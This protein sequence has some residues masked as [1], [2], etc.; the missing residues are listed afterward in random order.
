[1]SFLASGLDVA[2]INAESHANPDVWNRYATRRGSYGPHAKLSDIWVRYNDIRNLS[3]SRETFNEEHESV[4]YPEARV[5]PSVKDMAFRVMA[6]VG[7]ERLGG[8]L[9]TKIPPHTNCDPHVDRGWHATYYEKFAVQLQSDPLQAFHFEGE[10]FSAK[11]GDLYTFDNSFTHWV[12]NDSEVDRVTLIICIR[13]E[14]SK[15]V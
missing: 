6:M 8:V 12:T 7:G 3:D 4:W 2:R 5:L 11:P 13:T 15:R 9:I 10:S 1:M 14:R